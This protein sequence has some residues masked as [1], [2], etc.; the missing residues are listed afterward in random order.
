ML[1]F[2]YLGPRRSAIVASILAV[3][4]MMPRLISG[5][6]WLTDDVIGGALPALLVVSWLLATPLGYYLAKK[7]LPLVTFIVAL[8]PERLRIPEHTPS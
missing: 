7:L 1:F 8:I 3:I 2:I 4:F 6:H 5:A